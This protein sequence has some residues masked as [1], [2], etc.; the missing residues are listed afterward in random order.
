MK[1]YIVIIIIFIVIILINYSFKINSPVNKNVQDIV[2]II[3]PGQGVN[4]ISENLYKAKLINSKFYFEAYIWQKK[5]QS[6]LQAG[7]YI[8]N[9]MLSM[10]KVAVILSSGQV[11]DKEK[12][13]KIIEGWNLSDIGYYFESLGL[14]QAEEL[15]E[16]VGYPKV[17]YRV[18]KNMAIGKDYSDQ[19][20]FLA[21]KPKYYSLE[22]YLF[23]D[24]YRIFSD[25]SLDEI[26]VKMLS[27]F[28]KKLT[29]VMRN[30]INNQGKTIHDII[31]MA[32]IIEREVFAS[33]DRRVV[34]GIFWDRLKIGMPLQADS[35]VNYITSKKT[36]A[37]T[38][39][40]KEIDSP[41][42]TYKYKGL[43]SGPISN[44]GLNSIKAAI[45]PKK[46]EYLYFLNRQDTGET[47]FSKTLGEHN[48]NKAKYLR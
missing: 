44:P 7:Q 48:R 28:D 33:D 20:I 12:T 42:N 25:A 43:P 21:D 5:L 38:L 47:I 23:P 4:K 19:F 10:K 24:T 3:E 37:I 36:P 27:N 18:N 34:S 15:M 46:T 35:T 1:K 41:Y 13:I 40:D 9:S 6:D 8:L 39:E 45:Y 30:D 17:D 16:L 26:I 32:S 22:G 11:Q 29:E 14:F 2:F 31:I